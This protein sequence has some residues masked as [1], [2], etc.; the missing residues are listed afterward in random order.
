MRAGGDNSLAACLPACLPAPSLQNQKS[1][2]SRHVNFAPLAAAAAARSLQNEA[3]FR[4][5]YIKPHRR[6]RERERER[7]TD[8][9]MG[10][11][12]YL[13]YLSSSA[14][15]SAVHPSVS[16]QGGSEG[17]RERG[18]LAC[19]TSPNGRGRRRRGRRRRRRRPNLKLVLL[20]THTV[21]LSSRSVSL[22]LYLSPLLP[23][24]SSLPLQFLFRSFRSV[25]RPTDRPTDRPPTRYM[26]HCMRRL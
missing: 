6:E 2:A 18:R 26:L 14:V 5:L 8:D 16:Y 22:R 21:S 3:L 24:L 25:C 7:A 9:P 1:Y 23:F 4:F 11:W 19:R 10:K 12:A 13:L 20:K 17:A 15:S